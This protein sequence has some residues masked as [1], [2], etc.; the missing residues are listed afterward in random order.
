M[1]KEELTSSYSSTAIGGSRG[2]AVIIIILP[3]DNTVTCS[4]MS[5]QDTI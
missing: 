4:N 2:H 1:G 5:M 3:S